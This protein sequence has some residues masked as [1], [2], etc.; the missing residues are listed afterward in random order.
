M[1]VNKDDLGRIALEKEGVTEKSEGSYE[2]RRD[3]RMMFAP[4]PERVHPKKAR[5]KQYDMFVM[6]V[7]DADDKEALLQG[8]P[9]VF[10]TTNHYNGYA[11]V[12]VR[13]EAIDEERLLELVEDAWHAAP[14]TTKLTRTV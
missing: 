13:L 9:D 11:T 3:G 7:A 10:F 6:R 2:F 1:P 12:I 14:L 4:Y 5:V 8:E